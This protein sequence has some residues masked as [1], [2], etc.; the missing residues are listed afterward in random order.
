[1]ITVDEATSIISSHLSR[2]VLPVRRMPIRDA[3][4]FILA[5]DIRSLLDIPPFDKAAMDGF[6]VPEP[7]STR[8]RIIETVRAGEMPALALE[9]GTCTRIM[10][11]APVPLNTNRVIPVEHTSE[12]AGMMTVTKSSRDRHIMRRGE[13]L[14]TGDTVAVRGTRLDALH[15]AVLISSG[16]DAVDVVQKPRVSVFSTGDELVHSMTEWRPGKIFDSNGP[17]MTHLIRDAGADIVRTGHLPDDMDGTTAGIESAKADSDI[18][19]FSGGVSAGDYDFIPEA[20]SQCGFTIHFDTIRVK[21]GKP[22]T[23]A[24]SERHLA[25]GFPGNPVSTYLMLH[26]LLIPALNA[27]Q[28]RPH[29]PRM[30]PLPLSEPWSRFKTERLE[31]VPAVIGGN[32]IRPLPYHG[33]G[34]LASLMQADGF[35]CI[36]PGVPGFAAGDPVP[37]WPLT[38]KGYN[39]SPEE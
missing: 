26:L 9:P 36:D 13:D 8:Y 39:E 37:F 35:M 30:I 7:E 27:L 29:V 3:A 33:S 17:M 24:S 4:G 34:H 31:F 10:T 25:F 22:M 21:P 5:S 6:A 23:F 20:L 18:I 1:M 11:G 32:G 28:G 15:L 12:D 14:R 19:V 16:I 2:I 38:L